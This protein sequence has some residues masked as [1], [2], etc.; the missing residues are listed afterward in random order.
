M[1]IQTREFVI[2]KNS[3]PV[4]VMRMEAGRMGLYMRRLQTRFPD[5][6]WSISEHFPINGSD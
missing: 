2:R 5:Y 1:Q 3:Q 6:C 4:K